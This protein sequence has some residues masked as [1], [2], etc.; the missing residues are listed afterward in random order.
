MVEEEKLILNYIE[1]EEPS[2]KSKECNNSSKTLKTV[3]ENQN[4]HIQIDFRNVQIKVESDSD[5]PLLTREPIN[6]LNGER[7]A[8][9]A[10]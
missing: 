5:E 3:D 2:T 4:A 9:R 7:G 10:A 8:G 6:P 1:E